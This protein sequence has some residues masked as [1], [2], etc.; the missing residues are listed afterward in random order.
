MWITVL[1]N[2]NLKTHTF[3]N[4]NVA[5]YKLNYFTPRY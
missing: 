2:L 3:N 5:L 4:K 1:V